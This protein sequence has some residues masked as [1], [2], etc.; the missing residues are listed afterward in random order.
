MADGNEFR[1]IEV[2]RESG[3]SNDG[4]LARQIWNRDALN[5]SDRTVSPEQL[6]A[7][8][9]LAEHYEALAR[10]FAPLVERMQ[11]NGL[12]TPELFASLSNPGNLFSPEGTIAEAINV[13]QLKKL[14][15]K[16]E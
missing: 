1:P 11:R 2:Q 14:L 12:V 3:K 4:N 8:R 16:P 15:T 13:P 10:T 7:E 5:P 6:S 9:F